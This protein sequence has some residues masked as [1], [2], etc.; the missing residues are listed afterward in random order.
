[1]P[2]RLQTRN[3]EY[4]HSEYNIAN[5]RFKHRQ[6]Y[7]LKV[8]SSVIPATPLP[9]PREHLPTLFFFS[10]KNRYKPCKTPLT[11][12]QFWLHTLPQTEN[13]GGVS[14]VPKQGD[15]VVVYHCP[16]SDADYVLRTEPIVLRWD[17]NQFSRYWTPDFFIGRH[18]ALS[19]LFTCEIRKF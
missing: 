17:S 3:S 19:V 11:T 4:S 14:E 15:H 10:V 8:R 18:R 16:P 6:M 7:D 5:G 2:T 1:M 9:N 13:P 12:S